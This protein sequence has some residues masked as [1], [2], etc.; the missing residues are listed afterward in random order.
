[1]AKSDLL[2]PSQIYLEYGI[3][4]RALA[5]M[6]TCSIDQGSLVGPL[7]IN[8]KDTN[9]YLYKREW[10]EA[11]ITKDTVNFGGFSDGDRAVCMLHAYGIN[12][13]SITLKGFNVNNI[14]RW[15]GLTNSN[16]KKEKLKWMQKILEDLGY[17]IGF[18]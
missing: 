9:I 5:Y 17:D 1:M 2:K 4:T 6:R 15:S 16:L 14:G 11:W 8:P 3:K 7:W 13:E 18:K 10:I 12:K